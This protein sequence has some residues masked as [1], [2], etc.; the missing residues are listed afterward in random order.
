M[1]THL[2]TE[3]LAAAESDQVEA[4]DDKSR[5]V[6]PAFKF[7]FRPGDFAP[8]KNTGQPRISKGSNARHEKKIGMAPKG[9]RRSMG[10][11]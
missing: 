4:T 6:V 11:R 8:Q 3:D 5:P 2:S 1:T 10:K 7:P 9:T